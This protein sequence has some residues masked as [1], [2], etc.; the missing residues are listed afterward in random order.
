MEREELIERINDFRY[1][2]DLAYRSGFETFES[3]GEQDLDKFVKGSY[4]Y[5][6]YL[7][8]QLYDLDPQDTDE[9]NR[10]FNEI[11]DEGVKN[12][13]LGLSA[14]HIES[15][16]S[17]IER[18]FDEFKGVLECEMFFNINYIFVP[19]R[20][21]YIRDINDALYCL[22]YR[23]SE[24]LE[25]KETFREY[26]EDESKNHRSGIYTSIKWNCEDSLITLEDIYKEIKDITYN[27]FVSNKINGLAGAPTEEFSKLMDKF[28]RLYELAYAKCEG[29]ELFSKMCN[30]LENAEVIYH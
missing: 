30:D 14:R 20:A 13:L 17:E 2:M 19:G 26:S 1:Y 21:H 4:N 7:V 8:Y 28:D 3:L 24:V 12:E 5:L 15:T 10:Y 22:E 29:I 23:K 9:Y 16:V 6:T 27:S 11:N 25:I 18:A